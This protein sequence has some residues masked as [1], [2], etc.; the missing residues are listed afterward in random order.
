MNCS[1]ITI[2]RRAVAL[3][4]LLAVA[5]SAEPPGPAQPRAGELRP[6]AP[7]EFLDGTGDDLPT[8]FADVRSQALAAGVA[9]MASYDLQDWVRAR[10][11][12]D[13]REVDG[14]SEFSLAV[15]GLVPGG[16]YTVWLVR[17]L[18]SGRGTRM[19]IP[20]GPGFGGPAR[21]APG[22]NVLLANAAGDAS[23]KMA[24]AP[25]F[26]DGL[27]RQYESIDAWDELQL[28]F[29]ADNRGYG[30][31]PGPSHWVQ[32][33]VPLHEDPGV[34]HARLS[35]TVFANP[36]QFAAAMQLAT[37]AGVA[38]AAA[39]SIEDWTR[40]VGR[41]TAARLSLGVTTETRVLITAEGLIPGGAYSA[42]L[43]ADDGTLCALGDPRTGPNHG[44]RPTW[45]SQLA[46]DA[47]GRGFLRALVTPTSRCVDQGAFGSKRLRRIEV[48]FHAR[49]TFDA[50][51]AAPDTFLQFSF[52]AEFP[53]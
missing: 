48:H 44:E 30:F 8:P 25:D 11:T 53:S 38:A 3:S 45:S 20:L 32:G 7:E 34:L 39:Y 52:D 16:L 42:W 40:A 51:G 28:A 5:C 27:D 15:S 10:G 17:P 24:L 47:E 12:L 6:R 50:N 22:T 37:A 19:A 1:P 35:S 36:P 14:R 21:E 41:V 43:R 49:N 31:R 18:A 2:S 33:I 26:T 29:H 13:V 4:T 9:G 23:L 46:V